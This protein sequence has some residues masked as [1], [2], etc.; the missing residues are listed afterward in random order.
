ML[1]NFF[2]FIGIFGFFLEFSGFFWDF[3]D[4]LIFFE[5][6]WD[7]RDFWDFRISRIFCDFWDLLGSKVFFGTFLGFFGI[8]GF[9][10]SSCIFRIFRIFRIFWDFLRFQD[11]CDFFQ[12]FWD[13]K[14][15]VREFFL[16]IY[17]SIVDLNAC[18]D[19]FQDCFMQRQARLHRGVWKGDTPLLHTPFFI[20]I[21]DLSLVIL[22]KLPK[23]NLKYS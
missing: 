14:L 6:F 9:Y 16:V 11:F 7:F 8:Y 15:C 3:W 23:M 4:F 13:L 2:E 17:P 18:Y 10:G 5:I 12:I 22:K 20:R 1:L 19:T 21:S